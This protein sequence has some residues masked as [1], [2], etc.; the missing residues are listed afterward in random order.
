[1]PR[2]LGLVRGMGAVLFDMWRSAVSGAGKEGA[3]FPILPPASTSST[4]SL[5]FSQREA[6]LLPVPFLL[7]LRLCLF[8]VALYFT[9]H[10]TEF[11][12]VVVSTLSK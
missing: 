10:L 4:L 2:S 7:V 6:L 12:S 1:M 8:S 9:V 5:S 3:L 11:Y